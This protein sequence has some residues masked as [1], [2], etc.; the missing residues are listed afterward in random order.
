MLATMTRDV[1]DYAVAVALARRRGARG[2]AGRPLLGGRRFVAQ[3]RQFGAWRNAPGSIMLTTLHAAWQQSRR[4][5]H[6]GGSAAR[7]DAPACN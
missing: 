2:T 3:A 1:A 6:R 7:R 5:R 4:P